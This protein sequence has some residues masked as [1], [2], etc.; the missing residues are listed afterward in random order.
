MIKKL[1]VS[2]AH[3]ANVATLVAIVAV[4]SIHW[5]TAE[6]AVNLSDKDMLCLQ[7]NVYFESRNQSRL[8]QR[9]VAWVTLNRVTDQRYASTVCDVV[10]QKH[11]F[12][13]TT[14]SPR[15]IGPKNTYLEQQAWDTA[16]EIAEL[17]A[18][19]WRVGADDPTDGADHFHTASVKPK[20]RNSGTRTAQ[21]DDH[22]F[23]Q[24]SW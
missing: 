20:W 4:G 3:I 24:V 15:E 22:I 2:V 16:G 12:S 18:A 5:N 8:G 10:W 23:Y 14:G 9:A 1:V 17:V 19:R 7:Q 11:Q 6:A 21:I 13:W